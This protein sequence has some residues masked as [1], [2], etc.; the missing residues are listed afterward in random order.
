MK[1]LI[2]GAG[3]IVGQHLRFQQ[4]PGLTVVYSRRES[5]PLH[6][7]FLIREVPS[8]DLMSIETWLS[9]LGPDII[10]NLA[11]EN[12]PDLVEKD[13]TA[14]SFL[15]AVLPLRLAKW[16]DARGAFLI[17]ASSQAVFSGTRAPYGDG[18]VSQDEPGP[19]NAY[20]CQKLSA[21]IGLV[22][23]HRWCVARLTFVLGI[24]PLPR[25]GR[26]NPVE[27]MFEEA[28]TQQHVGD[29]WFS[30]L[31]ADDAAR[32]IWTIVESPESYLGC[33]VNVGIP[34]RWNR[35]EIAYLS[36]PDLT[37]GGI[38][39]V[40]HD[41]MPDAF[42]GLAQRPVDTTYA[43][44]IFSCP[45]SIGDY[46]DRCRAER[47]ALLR[48]DDPHDRA[49]EIAMF[50]GV[51]LETARSRLDQGFAVN[52]AAVARDWRTTDPKADDEILSWYRSTDAYIWELT[53]YHL[54]RGF[55]YLGMCEGIGLHLRRVKMNVAGRHLMRVLCLGDGIG[56]LTLVLLE[57]GLS[58]IYHDLA[59][60][61]TSRCA[62][63]RF[64]RRGVVPETCLTADWT[65][66]FGSLA[67][68]DAVIALD[69]FEHLTDV[70]AWARAV[71]DILRPGSTFLA[72]NAFG[73]GDETHEGS[74]PMH[75]VRNNIYADRDGASGQSGWDGLLLAIGFEPAEGGWW[76]KP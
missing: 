37:V 72:Q 31:C 66:S 73:I 39:V 32:A 74:I 2:L 16:C 1:I 42:P 9:A 12:S 11:G 58:P 10:I 14:T 6:I 62:L 18:P 7:G 52:H 43:V 55:N 33:I 23:F 22:E 4:P 8:D 24:R 56:D 64:A 3:G 54:D 21:E 63:F 46:L 5:D 51:N 57:Q 25:L 48:L 30:P 61:V 13:P 40:M 26:E 29:R 38:A 35:A 28:R 34:E 17:H 50:L 45:A 68:M 47:L 44:G 76:R 69:F 70:E 19:A 71:Y 65:P 53:A 60:S 41:N 75:L 67:Q 27:G 49:A 36:R 59:D 20:G 15:N